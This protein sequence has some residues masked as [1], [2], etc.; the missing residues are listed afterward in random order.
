MVK[1]FQDAN[2]ITKRKSFNKNPPLGHQSS[3]SSPGY[4]EQ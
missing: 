3:Q 2:H 4:R 1:C